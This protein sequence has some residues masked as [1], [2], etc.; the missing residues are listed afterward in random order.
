MRKFS[1]FLFSTFIPL[2]ILYKS[3]ETWGRNVTANLAHQVIK[4][5]GNYSITIFGNNGNIIDVTKPEPSIDWALMLGF[6]ILWLLAYKLIVKFYIKDQL[7]T[8][9]AKEK[10][11]SLLYLV[12][13]MV[14]RGKTWGLI[15]LALINLGAE[16]QTPY[17]LLSAL[18][19][20]AI[21][22]IAGEI[23]RFVETCK[24]IKLAK[25]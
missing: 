20:L 13:V 6:F 1:F 25:K 22:I 14:K 11:K 17:F 21:S 19:W 2:T 9:E 24:Q 12:D 15:W 8:M 23:L 7:D 5:G 18:T 3:Y 16:Y 10:K 4:Y